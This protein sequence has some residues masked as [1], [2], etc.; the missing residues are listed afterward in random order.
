[1]ARKQILISQRRALR[2]WAFSQQPRPTHRECV[3]WFQQQYD[4][5]ISQ[6]TISDSLSAH[7]E[8]VHTTNATERARIRDPKWP[9]LDRELYEWQQRT[10]VYNGDLLRTKA[11]Q[12]WHQLPQYK[13]QPCPKFAN[14]WLQKFRKRHGLS[15]SAATEAE[16]DGTPQLIQKVTAYVQNYMGNF[17]G[18]HDYAHVLRVLSLARTIAAAEASASRS[19]FDAQV[20]TLAALLHDVGDRKYL[21]PGQQPETM[22]Q[23]LLVELGAGPSLAKKIQTIV[24]A[25]SY[26]AEIKDPERVLTIIS[27]HPELA[28]VQDAD[29]LDAIGAIGIGRTFTFGGAKGSSS[30]N[31]NAV[32]QAQAPSGAPL[33]DRAQPE[34]G[35]AVAAGEGG[36]AP[37][38]GE[39]A[40]SRPALEP[41]WNHNS[42][43]GMQ[44][45]IEHFT[46]KLERLEGM[47]KTAEGKRL[48]RERTT[49][50]ETFRAWWEEEQAVGSLGLLDVM[51]PA[52]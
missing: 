23:F 36:P 25:V 46:D 39:L 13:D 9:D 5:R 10:G 2:E 11:E 12:L 37:T 8:I 47:M 16:A 41:E 26:S 34:S 31:N 17:D 20:I 40:V 35:T 28:V 50:L 49:R 14:G 24:S 48:A 21:Q 6:S 33:V 32:A 18:S 22:V 1:M 19:K 3:E 44:E 7:F 45:T 42:G 27:S 15:K 4:I 30:K 29:R 43:R 52:L 38:D 51:Q